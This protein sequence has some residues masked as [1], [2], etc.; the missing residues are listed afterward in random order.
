MDT[1]ASMETKL[2]RK[3]KETN[4]WP[5]VRFAVTVLVFLLVG[6][7]LLGGTTCMVSIGGIE[8]ACPLGVVQF[9]AAARK[10]IPALLV[11][12]AMGFGLI[13][14]FGRAFCGWI[15]PG[16]I[17]F[18]QKPKM[19][20]FQKKI[21]VWFQ[22]ALVGG[23]VGISFLCHNPL[24]CVICPAGV[25]CRGAIAA[26]S[27]GSVLPSIGWMGALVG[28]EWISKRSWCRDFCPLGAIIRFSSRLNPFLKFKANS[29]RCVPCKV[30]EQ[31][32]PEGINLSQNSDI[33]GCTKCFN[34]Q[35]ICPRE[36]VELK[37]IDM[38]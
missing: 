30:C 7:N 35:V 28:V 11:A 32:C 3:K 26:G 25:F 20:P 34:C 12:G 36:A 21:R 10:F 18:N 8:I 4:F 23:V 1:D 24:F 5:R 33:S 31:V 29:N 37:L 38:T 6:L 17:L 22:G 2:K 16:H 27:G 9:F 13:V 15:C 14:L 19:P